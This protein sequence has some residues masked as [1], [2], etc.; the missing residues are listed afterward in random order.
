MNNKDATSGG[1]RPSCDPLFIINS[2]AVLE[3][4]ANS[5]RLR[6]LTLLTEMELSVGDLAIRVELSQSALSQHLAKLRSRKL[7][8]TRR[9]GQSV[10][11]CC[12]SDAVVKILSIL[13]E[14]F[15]G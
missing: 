9:H 8:T 7:V 13:R 12:K 4:M 10:Y 6:V 1:E 5:S 14:L 15:D 3:A 2:N 11:Y